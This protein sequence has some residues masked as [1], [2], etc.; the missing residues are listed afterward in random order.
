MLA[1]DGIV[2]VRTIAPEDVAARVPERYLPG[3]AAADAARMPAIDRVEGWLE[4][5]GFDL[6]ATRRVLRNKRLT[7][8]DEERQLLVEARFRYAFLTRD[9]LDE[10]L[11]RM[12][13][14]AEARQGTWI[15]P[16][17]TYVLAASK[18]R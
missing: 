5:A 3:M 14:D 18:P 6:I 17:P 13:A 1:G 4:R 11:R 15:D 8:A 2:V 9:E 12:R 7:L 10:G 16:R